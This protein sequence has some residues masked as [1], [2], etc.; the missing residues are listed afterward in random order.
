MLLLNALF[1]KCSTL[2][3]KMLNAVKLLFIYLFIIFVVFVIVV[4]NDFFVCLTKKSFCI[5]SGQSVD[6]LCIYHRRPLKILLDYS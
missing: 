1:A 5:V 3:T 2:F 4:K 6:L